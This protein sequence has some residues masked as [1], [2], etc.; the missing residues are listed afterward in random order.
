M[1]TV[2]LGL[3]REMHLYENMTDH[4]VGGALWAALIFFISLFFSGMPTPDVRGLYIYHLCLFCANIILRGCII[5][6]ASTSNTA[7]PLLRVSFYLLF[8]A[9]SN[10]LNENFRVVSSHPYFHA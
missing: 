10:R 6:G 1:M 5:F 7:K 2:P 4:T 8:L 3:V 9:F